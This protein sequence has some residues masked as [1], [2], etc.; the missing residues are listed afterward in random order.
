MNLKATSVKKSVN[1]LL[2]S[3]KGFTMLEMLYAFAVFLIIVSFVPL[4]YKLILND[5]SMGSRLQT[6][7]WE[8]F[9]SQAKKEIRMSERIEIQGDKLLIGKGGS[10]ISYEKYGSKI[11]RRVDNAGHEILLQ[12]V[13]TVEFKGLPQG[14][15]ILVKDI[16]GREYSLSANSFIGLEVG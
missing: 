5:E 7:E 3:N 1:V 2:L 13:A 15:V 16:Y 11:R 14:V 10:I 4:S 8:V 6:M 9:A 12:N